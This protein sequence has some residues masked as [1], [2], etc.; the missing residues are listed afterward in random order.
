LLSNQKDHYEETLRKN[1]SVLQQMME[2]YPDGP[3]LLKKA[4]KKKK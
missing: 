2:K 4:S 1:E 3:I